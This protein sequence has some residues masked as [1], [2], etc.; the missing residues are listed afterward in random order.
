MEIESRE[1]KMPTGHSAHAKTMLVTGGAGLI[2]STLVKSLLEHGHQVTVIDQVAIEESTGLASV[3]ANPLLSYVQADVRAVNEYQEALPGQSVVFHLA[4]NTENRPEIA[5]RNA[6]V[7]VTLGGTMALLNAFA[8]AGGG[9][10]VLASTQLVYGSSQE[11]L[12]SEDSAA[13]RPETRFAA[14]KAA[15]EAFLSAYAR[16]F[17]FRAVAC[18]LCNIVGTSARRGVVVDLARRVRLDPSELAVLGDGRQERSFLDVRDCVAALRVAADS[19]ALGFQALNVTNTSLTSVARVAEIV[20]EEFRSL[21]AAPSAVPLRFGASTTGWAGDAPRLR[22][23][24]DVL[25]ARGW[26]P[27]LTSDES[28]RLTARAA[29]STWEENPARV[30]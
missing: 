14:G 28:V 1:C 19:A 29:L 13:I 12:L 21:H 7:T 6:D 17:G 10:F 26:R 9:T 18:R 5:D 27:E 22:L 30:Y 24:P 20:T 4:S 15:A 8:D 11:G 3:H 2:G 16:E 23:S 25:L